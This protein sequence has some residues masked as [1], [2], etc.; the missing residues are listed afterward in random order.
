MERVGLVATNS[1]RGGTNR[2]V[3]DRI[4]DNGAIFEAWSDE[5][6]VVDGA[7]VRVSLICFAGED[8]ELDARL[9]GLQTSRINADLTAGS[10]DMTRAVQ[11]VE[12]RGVA[13]QGDI[14]RGP[15]NIPG[16]LAREWLQLPANPNGRPKRRCAQTV[17]QRN[18]FDPPSV[19]QVD[20]GLRR[21]DERGR[22][23]TVRS[24]IRP[25]RRARATYASEEPGKGRVAN[26]GSGIGIRG[27]LCGRRSKAYPD[28]SS[29]RVSQSTGCLSGPTHPCARI[30]QLSQLPATTTPHSASCT[31]DSM[32]SGRCDWARAWKTARATPPLQPF[33]RFRSPKA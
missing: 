30:V 31:A 17:G 12:N 22:C 1:I 13:F 19:R 7:A 4:L 10:L 21:N 28:T 29:R 14:K 11:L 20:C 16:D 8:A 2:F 18:G 26:S 6:W 3:L 32:N 33:R 27:P 24:S 9:D 23:R 5:P 15:F 25:H